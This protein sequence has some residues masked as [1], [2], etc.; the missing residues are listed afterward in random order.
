MPKECPNRTDF[1]AFKTS[2]TLDLDD[3]SDQ[4]KGEVDQIEGCEK[5]RIEALKYLSSLQKKARERSVLA[6]KGLLYIDTWIN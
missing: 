5:P 6:E 3:K 2:L 4:A 1:Y